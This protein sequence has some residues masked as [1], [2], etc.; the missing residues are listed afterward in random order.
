MSDPVRVREADVGRRL[1]VWRGLVSDAFVPLDARAT[2]PASFRGG[3]I[4]SGTLGDVLV[5]EVSS[6]AQIVCRTRRTIDRGDPDV[7]KL[8]IQLRGRGVLAQD[9]REAVL[10]P[11]DFALYDTTRPYRLAFGEP[12][13]TLVLM[14]PRTLLDFG[15]QRM[16]RLT[17]VRIPGREGLGAAVSPFLTRVARD[18]D[19]LDGQGA[20]RI[21]GNAL[22]LLTTVFAQVLDRETEVPSEDRRAALAARIEEYAEEHLTDPGLTPDRIADAH[23]ISV[24]YLHRIFEPGG[25]TVAGWIRAR[26]L[27]RARRDLADPLL[28][29]LPVSAIGARWAMV[30]ASQFSRLFRNAYGVTP[31]AHRAARNGRSADGR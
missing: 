25:V 27:E 30:D 20:A 26:R 23:H 9:G 13:R 15:P 7:Y 12:F 17:A 28:D 8:G 29:S 4:R 5:S 14:F 18:A 24:R 22:A 10:R 11:G 31:T 1:D 21:G 2:D 3:V 6:D 16:G 19:A